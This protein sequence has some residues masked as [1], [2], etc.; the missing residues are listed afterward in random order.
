MACLSFALTRLI[1]T[2]YR[3]NRLPIRLNLITEFVIERIEAARLCFLMPGTMRQ[4]GHH[5]GHE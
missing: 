3:L 5:D 2:G 1:A 4:P